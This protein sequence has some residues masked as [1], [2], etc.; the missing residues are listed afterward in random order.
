VT[1]EH[2]RTMPAA[3]K[4][5]V[6]IGSRPYTKSVWEHKKVAVVTASLGSFG[7][8]NSGMDVRKSMQ[9]LSA[10]VMIDP[11]IYLSR[12][13]D[14]LNQ[15]GSVSERTQKFLQGFVTEFIKFAGQSPR[16]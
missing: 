15:D 2:N 3:L 14:S 16:D 5:V 10:E 12:A 6:D 7:G 4:N 9:M 8:I 13:T 11:E 1:P